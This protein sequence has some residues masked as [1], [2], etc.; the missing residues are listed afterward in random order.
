MLYFVLCSIYPINLKMD[1]VRIHIYTV[2]VCNDDDD[3]QLTI[4]ID[5]EY[6]NITYF[7]WNI[8]MA[9]SLFSLFLFSLNSVS[10]SSSESTASFVDDVVVMPFFFSLSL[11]L[12]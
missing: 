12:I 7:K 3:D 5:E 2:Q 10:Q 1:T 11:F 6:R 4:S 9:L 8:T